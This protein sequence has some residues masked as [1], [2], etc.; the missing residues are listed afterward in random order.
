MTVARRLVPRQTHFVTRRARGRC[1]YLLPTPEVKAIVLYALGRAQQLAPGV[2]LHAC[3]L[4]VT[5]KHDG[6]TDSPGTSQLSP[7]LRE[8]HSLTARALNCHYGR[9]ENLWRSESY[10]NVEVHTEPD[11]EEQLLYV[12]CQPVRDG[13][14]PTPDEWPGVLFFPEDLGTT[15]TVRKPDEAFFGGRRPTDWEPTHPPAR[16]AHRA[17]LRRRRDADRRREKETDRA[18]GR[19]RARRRHLRAEQERRQRKERAA[20]RPRR[21]RSTLP[22]EVTITISPPPGYEDWPIEEVRAHFRARLDERVAQLHAERQ[23]E[24]RTHFMGL[25]RAMAQDPMSSVGD[26]FP[27]FK[28]NPR[29]A[30]KDRDLRRALL[31]GLQQWR[32]DYHQALERWRDLDREVRFPWGAYWIPHFHGAETS[33]P[34]RGPPVA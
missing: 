33:D 16:R 20:A 21:D 14:T 31:R 27:S 4:E 22:D 26:T 30:C 9:G 7:F 6:M 19:S 18:Q 24:G 17:E 34:P 8:F 11:L 5:H 10:D 29:I 1:A 12:W 15:I 25:E 32:S 23:A 2:Q 3:T 13:L 28:R